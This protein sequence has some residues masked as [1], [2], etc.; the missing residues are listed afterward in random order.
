MAAHKAYRTSS[1][2]ASGVRINCRRACLLCIS[3][4]FT[5]ACVPPAIATLSGRLCVMN[6]PSDIRDVEHRS[7]GAE[8]GGK[9]PPCGR[10]RPSR[11]AL[12]SCSRTTVMDKACSAG[13]RL[14][15]E[16]T[17]RPSIMHSFSNI[18]FVSFLLSQSLTFIASRCRTNTRAIRRAFL[19]STQQVSGRQECESERKQSRRELAGGE[20]VIVGEYSELVRRQRAVR[21]SK[22]L[23]HHRNYVA[24]APE[25]CNTPAS[26]RPSTPS[27]T[28]ISA[29]PLSGR[30]Y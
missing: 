16:H 11:Q 10:H 12:P 8:W 30:P 23:T 20:T 5:C 18:L 6:R 24:S 21:H 17:H 1:S 27:P 25:Q 2:L 14:H 13:A 19:R 4:P 29:L 3:V 26:T 28:T 9:P 22:A 15:S 7:V